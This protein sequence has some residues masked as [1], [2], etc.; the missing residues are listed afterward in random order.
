MKGVIPLDVFNIEVA[1][2]AKDKHRRKFLRGEGLSPE[3]HSDACFASAHMDVGPDGKAWF[4]MVIKPEATQATWAHECVHI[5]DFLMDRLG[6]PTGAE[7]TEIRAYIVG[8]LFAGLQEVL[9]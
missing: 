1:V 8:R 3:K 7:N 4:S 2:F 5:A 9:T 6:I